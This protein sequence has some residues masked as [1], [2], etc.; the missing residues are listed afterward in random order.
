[1]ARCTS[2]PPSA[3]AIMNA[4][5]P[6]YV[7]VNDTSVGP[8]AAELVIRGIEH[9]NILPE[10]L[11]CQV[12]TATWTPLSSVEAF[13]S[14]VIRS[15][16][17][18]PPDSEDARYW[19]EHG[20]HFPAPAALPRFDDL[21]TL[22][23]PAVRFILPPPAPPPR[24]HPRRRAPRGAA[25]SPLH[26]SAGRRAPRGHAPAALLT[27]AGRRAPRASPLRPSGLRPSRLR[28]LPRSPRSR[29]RRSPRCRASRRRRRPRPPPRLP[30]PSSRRPRT[31]GLRS[32]PPTSWSTWTSTP[33]STRPRSTSTTTPSS[34]HPPVDWSTRFQ[35]YF[36]VGEE[37]E[38]P[39]EEALLA[40]LASV[41][42]DTFQH[43]E[44]LW[45]LALCM[46]FGSD[47]VGEA[48]A[49][50]FYDVVLQHQSLDRLE[51][52]SRTLLGGGFM[53]SGI[54]TD[55]AQV[56]YRRLQSLCPPAL[57]ERPPAG[58]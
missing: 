12:G 54:P 5:S 48:A 21:D 35:S 17:P 38:L 3:P 4:T 57:S 49:R 39:E 1:M 15:Y 13:H 20:F 7:A 56:A 52:M 47:A 16:P 51:W 58:P 41:P 6:W 9:R 25:S 11:V 8:V 14:A 2:L 33:S 23:A 43:D 40:S 36:L 32:R 42:R 30:S 28:R 55:A 34:M 46:A 18:P 24:A 26:A 53:P 50:E 37:V 19:L 45:N 10:A 44:A 31:P 22:G 29:L 27:S